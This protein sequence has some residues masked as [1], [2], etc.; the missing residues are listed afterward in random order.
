MGYICAWLSI[1]IAVT[2]APRKANFRNLLFM[3]PP[4]AFAAF[5]LQF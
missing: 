1:G 3:Y 4:T 5:V 2:T